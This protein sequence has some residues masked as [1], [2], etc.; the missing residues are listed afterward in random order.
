MKK[1]SVL[2]PTTGSYQDAETLDEC[3]DLVSEIAYNL[4]LNYTRNQP[5]SVVEIHDDGSETW[6]NPAGEEILS[7]DQIK[8]NIKGRGRKPGTIPQTTL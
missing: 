4:L 1:Y 7:P 6:Q 3:L 5:Y 2:N 8:L